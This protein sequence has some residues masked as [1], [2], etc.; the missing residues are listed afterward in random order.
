MNQVSR[1]FVLVGL[2]VAILLA[3]HFLPS[4]SLN[5]NELRR[6]NILSEVIP[7]AHVGEQTGIIPQIPDIPKLQRWLCQIPSIIQT[8]LHL[9]PFPKQRMHQ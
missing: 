4:F 6:V 3:A 2:V 5:D 7:E 1:T 9:I 8:R